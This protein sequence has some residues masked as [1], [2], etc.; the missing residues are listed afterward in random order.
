MKIK[1]TWN[2]QLGF[3]LD[4]VRLMQEWINFE[5]V[6]VI[7]MDVGINYYYMMLDDQFESNCG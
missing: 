6:Q 1:D 5:P 7:I 3:E 4:H 2:F